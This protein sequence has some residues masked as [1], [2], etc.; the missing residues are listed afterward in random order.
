[1]VSQWTFAAA[2]G[3]IFDNCVRI[4]SLHLRLGLARGESPSAESVITNQ[5]YIYGGAQLCKALEIR[6]LW[7]SCESWAE[8]LEGAYGQAGEGAAKLWRRA[9]PFMHIGNGDL[10]ALNM[11]GDPENPPVA[12]LSHE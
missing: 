5:T 10:L 8:S 3:T 6:E 9:I 12:Y 1:M 11:G 7:Q 2:H 4:L